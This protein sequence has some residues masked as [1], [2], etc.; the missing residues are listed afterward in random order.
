MYIRKRQMMQRHVMEYLK[1]DGY[2]TPFDGDD[3]K[4]GDVKAIPSDPDA[5]SFSRIHAPAS[6]VS[7]GTRGKS[8]I[9]NLSV[10]DLIASDSDNGNP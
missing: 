5:C 6:H 4:K 1:K 7:P 8:S 10:K 3:W 9:L 2:D